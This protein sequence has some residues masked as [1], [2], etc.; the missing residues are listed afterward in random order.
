MI[1]KSEASVHIMSSRINDL[2]FTMEKIRGSI[3]EGV[4]VKIMTHLDMDGLKEIGEFFEKA[5]VKHSLSAFD[6]QILIVD[7]KEA[8][9]KISSLRS[10]DREV[11]SNLDPYVNTLMRVFE[12]YWGRGKLA[13]EIISRLASQ[14]GG[15]RRT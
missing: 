8:L 10:L 7:E 2:P 3:G 11:W 9:M 13:D 4:K 12:D 1:S 15:I 14:R 5:D 6:L